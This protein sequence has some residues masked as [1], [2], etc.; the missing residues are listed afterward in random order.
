MLSLYML[1]GLPC[2]KILIQYYGSLWAWKILWLCFALCSFVLQVDIIFSSKH[3]HCQTW[4]FAKNGSNYILQGSKLLFLL[5]F[6]F[7]PGKQLQSIYPISHCCNGNFLYKD[8]KI[9][10]PINTFTSQKCLENKKPVSQDCQGWNISTI[11]SPQA[12]MQ[13]VDILSF[14]TWNEE[15]PTLGTDN[16][17]EVSAHVWRG[18]DA[19]QFASTWISQ[20]SGEFSDIGVISWNYLFKLFSFIWMTYY[21]LMGKGSFKQGDLHPADCWGIFWPRRLFQQPVVELLLLTEPFTCSS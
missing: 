4:H 21:W 13:T 1:R 12:R 2:L 20:S 14:S 6:F 18:R 5:I 16:G 7:P 19:A 8:A 15:T 17:W 10:K 3:R 11:I 9:H